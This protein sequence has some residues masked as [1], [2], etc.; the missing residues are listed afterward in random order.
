MFFL[1]LSFSNEE[2][3]DKSQGC[4]LTDKIKLFWLIRKTYYYCTF[5]RPVPTTNNKAEK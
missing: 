1:L 2:G 4:F 5:F 3:N